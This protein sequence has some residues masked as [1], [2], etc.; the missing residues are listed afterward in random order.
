MGKAHYK[1][2][3]SDAV[4]GYKEP[5]PLYY[6]YDERICRLVLNSS[7]PATEDGANEVI[8]FIIG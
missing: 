3:M 8:V 5:N 1:N 6:L 7:H 4:S 2:S